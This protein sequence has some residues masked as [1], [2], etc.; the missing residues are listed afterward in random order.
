MPFLAA[1]GAAAVRWLVPSAAVYIA[2]RGIGETAEG[3]GD[4]AA[5]G[6]R[7]L[8]MV[9]AAAAAGAVAVKYFGGRRVSR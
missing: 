3:V 9:A 1:F 4:M 6:G 7:T 5:S 8:V 2:G